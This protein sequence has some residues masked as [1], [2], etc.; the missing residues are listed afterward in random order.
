MATESEN[1]NLWTR[2]LQNASAHFI[3]FD[4]LR[5]PVR[6]AIILCHR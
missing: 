6:E 2:Q 5:N 4:P 1:F 3:S